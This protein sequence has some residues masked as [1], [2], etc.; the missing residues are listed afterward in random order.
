MTGT[1]SLWS[2][3]AIYEN[4]IKGRFTLE[5]SGHLP[6]PHRSDERTLTDLV[7][8]RVDPFTPTIDLSLPPGLRNPDAVVDLHPVFDTTDGF[9]TTLLGTVTAFASNA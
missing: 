6:K 4:R 5:A 3:G 7:G 9:P 2:L 8:F 1:P